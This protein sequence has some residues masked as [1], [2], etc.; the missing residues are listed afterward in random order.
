M[1]FSKKTNIRSIIS[2]VLA[3]GFVLTTNVFAMREEGDDEPGSFYVTPPS[4]KVEGRESLE[5]Q[6]SVYAF[7]H[8]PQ[9]LL[10]RREV[11]EKRKAEL[12]EVR[13]KLLRNINSLPN[14]CRCVS[15][16]RLKRKKKSTEAGAEA[17]PT[18]RTR[19][20]LVE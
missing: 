15:Y 17:E 11:L 14:A 6:E 12:L 20:S 13:D 19:R 3:L 4:S 2:L 18:K 8:D 10:A 16:Q 1:K 9:K 5:M 7:G